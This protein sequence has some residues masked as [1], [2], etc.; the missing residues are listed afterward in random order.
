MNHKQ[1]I[2]YLFE[3]Q[4]YYLDL[5]GS[6]IKVNFNSKTLILNCFDPYD[7]INFKLDF[8]HTIPM[9]FIEQRIITFNDLNFYKDK[10]NPFKAC[11]K[12]KIH[13]II[14]PFGLSL[15]FQFTAKSYTEY[16]NRISFVGNFH[17]NSE[18]DYFLRI[19][20]LDDLRLGIM[21]NGEEYKTIENINEL[22][23]IIQ[24]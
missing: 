24:K 1:R 13:D 17:I 14:K 8:G 10:F 4:D 11:L 23:K 22:S 21:K 5:F 3:I 12:P 9:A 19:V 2:I 15:D 18:K 20:L 16:L 7:N 6:N